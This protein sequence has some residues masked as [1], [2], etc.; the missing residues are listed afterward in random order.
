LIREKRLVLRYFVTSGGMPSA[1]SAMVSALATAAAITQGLNSV[2]FAIAAVVAM[3]VMYDAAG[4]RLAVSR[5]SVILDRVVK[6]L[7]E[8]RPRDEVGR[9]LRR[10]I[11]H[12][13][14]QV[15]AGAV[16]GF[17]TAWLWLT[18]GGS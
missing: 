5:Q 10:F 13:P 17:L 2:A 4:V 11:G 12:T 18:I 6:E 8:K 15:I 16:L 9:D 3:V 1:H 14:F 7:L